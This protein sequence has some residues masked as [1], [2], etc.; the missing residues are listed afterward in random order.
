MTTESY[1]SVL[2]F[3][4]ISEAKDFAGAT[5]HN[6]R[7]KMPGNADP[8]R[9][10]KNKTL[11]GGAEDFL[12]L[13]NARLK[14][15]HI[16]PRKNACRALE[17]IL[18]AGPEFFNKIS[19]RDQWVKNATVF[20]EQRYGKANIVHLMAHYDET[21]P[22]L[23]AIVVPVVKAN[24]HNG[25]IR[26]NRKKREWK[27]DAKG[28]LESLEAEREMGG[29]DRSAAEFRQADLTTSFR[30]IKRLNAKADPSAA[31]LATKM[32]PATLPRSLKTL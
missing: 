3:R 13:V 15:C 8:K 27:L 11:I 29:I 14:E 10:W 30:M 12:E 24:D 5:A 16:K 28:I 4:K 1:S 9:R 19:S 18:T 23:H 20:L 7:S 6:L 22:H 25:P 21:T 26:K 17:F 32:S 31:F 2:R